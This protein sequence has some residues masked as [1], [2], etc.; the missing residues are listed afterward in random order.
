MRQFVAV[1][2]GF[3]VVM[4]CVDEISRF[5]DTSAECADLIKN[6]QWTGV[7]GSI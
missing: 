2:R 3:D 7:S 6:F 4:T 1:Q 5:K